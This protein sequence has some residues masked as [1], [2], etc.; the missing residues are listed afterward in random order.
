[1]RSAKHATIIVKRGGRKAHHGVHTGAWKVAF[2]DFMLALMALFMVLWIIGA[3]SQDERNQIIAQL[4]G[5][6]FFDGSAY[7]PIPFDSGKGPDMMATDVAAPQIKTA[8]A[9]ET[10]PEEEANAPVHVAATETGPEALDSVLSRSDRELQE[11][12]EVIMRI[13]A[14]FSAQ[15]NLS[16][17]KVP[18][19]LRIL[20]HD[21]HNRMMFP[22]G[23]A[24]LTPYF[25][26][27]IT[28]LAPVFNR[29]DNQIMIS[30]HTDAAPYSDHAS[31]NNWNLSGDRA[32]AARRALEKG[33]VEHDRIIQVNA[34]AARMPI[35]AE[36]PLG[37]SNRRIEIMVLTKAAADTLYQFY[38]H[39][40]ERV[41]KPATERIRP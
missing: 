2:A 12:S 16:L 21:D 22:R 37:A 5:I 35:D 3:V 33:G 28:E 31:Y 25:Q 9:D 23:S 1:M 17:E 18:H 19:G 32:L 36:D 24:E 40:G 7:K 38:G 30:G 11:L 14:D 20:L 41:V 39:H 29:I 26:R 8:I 10:P 34:M 27:L 4:H 6:T 13:T 15:S